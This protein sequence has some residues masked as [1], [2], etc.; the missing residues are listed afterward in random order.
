MPQRKGD[1]YVLPIKLYY[2]TQSLSV[3][4][5]QI[6]VKRFNGIARKTT[7]LPQVNYFQL[8]FES[9]SAVTI[10]EYI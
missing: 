10:L 7:E 4:L 1:I 5:D 8:N 3:N 2:E 9:K 6:K